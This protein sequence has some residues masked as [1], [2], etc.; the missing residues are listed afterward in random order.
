MTS[1]PI[2]YI[3]AEFKQRLTQHHLVV[4]AETGSGK[5]TR[6]PIWAMEQGRVLVVEPRR[7]AC[8]SLAGF[9]AE[10][11]LEKVG[12]RIGYAI[13]LESRYQ[14]S[15]QVIFVT[16]GVAL[17]WFADNQL[18]AFDIVIIDEFHERRWDTDLL[19]ALLKQ[20][21]SH[22]T[23][24]TSAT[25]EGEKLADYFGA[26]RLVAKG[27]NYDVQI[28]HIRSDSRQL[29]DSRELD[30]RIRQAIASCWDELT[31]DVLVFLPGRKEIQQA[32]STLRTFSDQ[33]DV[34]LAPLY[35]AVTDSERVLAMTAQNKRKIVLATNIA[36]TSLTIPNIELVIDSG[37]ER[38]NV[39]RNGH[40]TL[41]L[42]HI[43]KASATQ[44]SGR[45]GRVM[46]GQCIR[47]YGEHAALDRVT[48]PELQR[49]SIVEPTLAAATCGYSIQNLSFIDAIPNKALEQAQQQLRE[50]GALDDSGVTLHGRQLYPLPVDTIYADLITKMPTKAL[51]E[52]MID[53]T[54]AL[55]A[56]GNLYQLANNEE[57]LDSL[58]KQEPDGC[59][60]NL[61][62]GLVRGKIFKGLIVNEE[63]L[64]EA[65]G[66]SQQMREVFELPSLEVASR[67]DRSQWCLEMI[68]AN[69]DLLFVRRKRRKEALGNGKMEV[70]LGR[71]TRMKP[72]SEAALV[73]SIHSLP[74]RG[75]KETMSLATVVMPIR[76][77]MVEA[78]GVG[79]WLAKETVNTKQGLRGIE[80]LRYAGRT[81]ATRELDLE[82]DTTLDVIVQTIVKEQV[83]FGLATRISA[84]MQH[85]KLYLDLGLSECKKPTEIQ[86]LEEWLAEQLMALGVTSLNDLELLDVEDFVFDGIP[87]WEYDDFAQ[88]YPL[89]IQ[90]SGLRL[91]VAYSG[92]SK[93]VQI[94]FDSGSRK[95]D[96]LRKELPSW[97]G[98]KVRYKKASRVI[99]LR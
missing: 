25:I 26:K 70:L 37:L 34:V 14:E 81:I 91:T 76:L 46:N 66:L 96:P 3:E 35:A 80:E 88:K 30:V 51:K 22:K 97:S 59:D 42:G 28:Q 65:R 62:V 67:Y 99:D 1:L 85:W 45:A 4:E 95:G 79:Q 71:Q 31:G 2:D 19:V 64:K 13:K 5:S 83:L 89:K 20:T 40:T 53:L 44:R 6:L 16:P 48:P 11:L 38:R 55:C 39:Q 12:Q 58:D 61:L 75:L 92:R 90:L 60:G 27:R 43:S 94:S 86:T 77:S 98:W 21:Q 57:G 15:S 82:E 29:P 56:T 32:V 84:Q 63:G 73:L 24:I 7:I 47:L 69:K 52:V 36:E 41:M 68:N 18:S 74:G 33:Y 8:T 50:L 10:S 87:D 49:E 54:A 78:A 72:A 9:M 17:R 93:L 23:V